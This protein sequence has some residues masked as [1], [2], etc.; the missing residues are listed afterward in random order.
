[1]SVGDVEEIPLVTRSP[2]LIT[3]RADLH[4]LTA[5]TAY[6][7][8][9]RLHVFPSPHLG[10][11]RRGSSGSRGDIKKIPLPCFAVVRRKG[12]APD[13]TLLVPRVPAKHHDDRF[14]VECVFA[15]EMSDAVF[16]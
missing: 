13:W 2:E 6:P 1:M 3:G 14:P 12:L 15:K 8:S 11:P 9:S 4:I 5:L 10:S 7:R 16:K